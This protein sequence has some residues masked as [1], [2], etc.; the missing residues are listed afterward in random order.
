MEVYT[1]GSAE[2]TESIDESRPVGLIRPLRGQCLVRLLPHDYRKGSL[3]LP[4]KYFEIGWDGKSFPRKAMVVAIGA[5]RTT[6]D[7]LSILPDFQPGQR[8][9][10]ST[11]LGTKL[12]REIGAN[13][14]LVR[15]DDV[16]ATLTEEINEVS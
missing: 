5:W 14:M 7:G 6:K 15:V 9:L 8:V 13:Y 10:V 16:L 1:K 2:R 4:D 12:T 3:T 11:Y